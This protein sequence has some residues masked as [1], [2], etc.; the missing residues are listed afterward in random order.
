MQHHELVRMRS[1]VAPHLGG[2]HCWNVWKGGVV[3]VLGGDL[4]GGCG[5]DRLLHL[6]VRHCI[7]IVLLNTDDVILCC[8]LNVLCTSRYDQVDINIIL[9]DDHV[10][11]SE[12]DIDIMMTG[13]HVRLARAQH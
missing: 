9:K 10:N 7:L 8:V 13:G 5:V 2:F 12:P 1:T 6:L 11:Y 3:P 4:L